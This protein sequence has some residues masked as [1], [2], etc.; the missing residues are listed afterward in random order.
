MSEQSGRND[1]SSM[2]LFNSPAFCYFLDATDD[3]RVKYT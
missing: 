1:T 3:N 2:A